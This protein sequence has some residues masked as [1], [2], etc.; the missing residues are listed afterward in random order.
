MQP[1]SFPIGLDTKPQFLHSESQVQPSII[2][3]PVRTVPV[4]RNNISGTSAAHDIH[5]VGSMGIERAAAGIEYRGDVYGT[6]VKINV[7]QPKVN[8]DSKDVSATWVHINN[9]VGE[10]TDRIGA[11]IMVNPSFSGDTSVRFHIAWTEGLEKK[12]C[13]DQSCRG[14]VQVNRK[15][16]PGVRLD[17]V[18]VYDGP[19]WAMI[20]KIFKDPKTK[21]WWVTDGK[22]IPLGYWP[23]GLF[24]FLYDKGN[25]AFWG[26]IV[27]GPTA[28]S[29]AVEMG[30][31]HFASEGYRRAAIIRNIQILNK[32]NTY[33]TPEDDLKLAHGTSNSTLYTIDKFRV[34]TDGLGMYYGGPGLVA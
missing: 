27:Q 1:S 32:N 21:N 29:K 28:T 16:A 9:G 19:Q 25:F 24:T 31:G 17:H 23:S 15:W 20:I 7:W 30:S 33:V 4:L 8:K 10:H 22:N 5:V 6:T 3:C 18:S 13:M 34:D 12:V 26:G 2:D 11:G 14:F